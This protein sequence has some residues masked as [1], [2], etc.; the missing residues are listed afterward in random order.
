[1]PVR[2]GLIGASDIAETRMIPAMNGVPE[3]SVLAVVSSDLE[4]GQAYAQRNAI[5]RIYA[6]LD[7][8]LADPEIVAVYISTTNQQHLEQALAAASAGKHVLCEKPLALSVEDALRMNEACRDAGVVFGTNHHL[9]NAVIHR[10]IRELVAGG[11]VG[12]PLAARV[13]HAVYL[14]PRL[15]G[16]RLNSSVAGG[17]VLLDI[18]VH[19]ADTLRFDLS[20]DPL[21]VTAM[22]ANHGMAGSDLEDSAMTIVRFTSGVLAQTHD[23]FTIEHARTGFE[24][25][26]TEGSIRCTE[27]M[28]QEPDGELTLVDKSGLHSIDPGP[29]ENLYF[30][31][32]N[33]F[34]EA[35][36]GNG[37]PA[38]TGIDGIWSLATALA[39]QKSAQSGRT[40]PV[41]IQVS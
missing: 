12:I 16:W 29:P 31:S 36:R 30:R 18:N 10:K 15:Q 37:E 5:P 3:S 25:H 2:W 27:A 24:V 7:E 6:A 33:M 39:A 9:R 21:E 40:V 23:A 22:T 26:G 13:F 17:G 11:A 20:A 14:P 41:S 34:N 1:M 28:T 4:R 38:A 35:I 19:D 32:V 8:L